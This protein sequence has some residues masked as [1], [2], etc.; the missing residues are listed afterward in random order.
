MPLIPLKVKID[1]T[2]YYI[3]PKKEMDID[4]D[5]L[6]EELKKSLFNYT[7]LCR[8]RDYLIKKR[9]LLARE[10]EEAY[11]KAWLFYKDTNERWNND[12]VSNK[13]NTNSKYKSLSEKYIKACEAASNLISFCRAYENRIDVLRTLNANQRKLSV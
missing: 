11:S 1:G 10:K 13:A 2:Y 3:D 5:N 12:Y 4:E 8:A 9:D 7:I 6:D